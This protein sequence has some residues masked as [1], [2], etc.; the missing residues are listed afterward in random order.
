MVICVSGQLISLKTHFT[1]T[2]SRSSVEKFSQVKL[3]FAKL[4][5]L[6]SGTEL[7][8]KIHFLQ[9]NAVCDTGHEMIPVG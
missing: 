7:A 4:L 2:S 3:C 6:R 8:L 5:G 1:D 9:P